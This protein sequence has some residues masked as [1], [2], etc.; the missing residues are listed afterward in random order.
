MAVNGILNNVSIGSRQVATVDAKNDTIRHVACELL[1]PASAKC[2]RCSKC[3]SYRGSLRVQ[4]S[5]LV[6]K[7][8]DRT[9]PHSHT[10]YSIL[11][12]DEMRTRMSKLHSEL[13]RITKQRDRLKERLDKSVQENGV[14]VSEC[15]SC[16]LKAIMQS[17]GS[18][19]TERDECT[20][21]QKV[22]WQQQALASSKEDA[23]GMRWHPLMIKWC[24]YLRAH[25]QGAYETLR[26]SKCIQLP[27]QRTLRDYTHHLKPGP[28]F[29]AGVDSQLQSAVQIDRCEEKEKYVLLLLDEMHV[30]QD[31][32]YNKSTGELVGFVN[33]GDINMHL[34]ALEQSL[35]SPTEDPSEKLA[36]T[37]LAFMVKGLLSPLEFPYAN[38]PCRNLTGDLMF[39]PFWEAV[40]RLER[41]G[42]KV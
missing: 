26:Q 12:A 21:F 20:Y 24:I 25:S 19:A 4:S 5:R 6:S 10:P 3:T 30:K 28:G 39:D 35:S 1:I 23:R 29:S 2:V 7:S 41:L 42:L 13:R 15:L 31:L 33:L 34:L 36:S 17:E 27:S 40:H 38:F 11:S 8:S 16:D 14:T 18:K 32:V 9:E 22:F 37:V